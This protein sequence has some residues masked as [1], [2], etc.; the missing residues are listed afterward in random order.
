[1]VIRVEEVHEDNLKDVCKADGKYII[2]KK[3]DLYVENNKITYTISDVPQTEKRYKED[4]IDY[5]T[6]IDNPDKIIYVAY[7]DGTLAGQ[8]IL[9]KNWNNYAYI[10][11]IRVDITCR[12]QGVGKTL[13]KCAKDWA[14]TKGLAGVML[15]TQNNNVAA[16]SLYESC[17]FVLGGFDTYLYKGLKETDEI[18]L[19]W[20]YLL[21]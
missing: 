5:R 17:G 20:Y 12:N 16:C 14:R 2:S 1:M 19:Y 9:R 3:L 7:I 18:A 13:L 8:I 15:E 4:D 10:E 6:Y 21:I 11:D